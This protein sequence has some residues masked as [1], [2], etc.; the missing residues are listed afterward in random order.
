[1]GA[2]RR[3]KMRNLVIAMGLAVAVAF[4]AP[5]LAGDKGKSADYDQAKCAC[6]SNTARTVSW[7][8]AC[9]GGVAFGQ[10][11]KSKDL[12]AALAG[13]EMKASGIKCSGCKT[14]F[15]KSGDC[16]H[17]KLGF[18]QGLAFHSPVSLSLAK[19]E[20]INAEKIDCPRC[21][22]IAE[23]G[24][25][26]CT[27]CKM[28]VVAG[29]MFHGKDDYASARKANA[30]LARAIKT[31]DK[32][33]GCAVAMVGDGTCQGCKVSFKDGKKVA[34]AGRSLGS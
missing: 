34:E 19:G 27:G 33:P 18:R 32:C 15:E 21:K 13:H 1:M 31:S 16:K 17:C 9:G 24:A 3:T 11:I 22:A 30:V 23:K 5:A 26:E 6:P 25:G 28:G 10:R 29:L 14:A 4:V 2:S 20:L 12:V 7:C 8:E